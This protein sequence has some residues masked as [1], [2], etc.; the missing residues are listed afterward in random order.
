ML[1]Q[2]F[3]NILLVAALA[4]L[5][6]GCV[7]AA[8]MLAATPTASPSP[9]PTLAPYMPSVTPGVS[10]Q[11]IDLLGLPVQEAT[12]YDRYVAF[13]D[14]YIYEYGDSTLLDAVCVNSYPQAL[15]GSVWIEFEDEEG[16]LI[17]RAQISAADGTLNLQ[18]GRTPVYAHIG[19]DMD[20]QMMDF[21]LI[22]EHSF[23]PIQAAEE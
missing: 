23:L 8:P 11:E 2:I 21:K 1:K 6:G 14:I 19:T 22:Y 10:M 16:V 5:C 20:V 7:Y 17:A 18:P 9:T 13:E 15:T 12:H 3:V 4:A